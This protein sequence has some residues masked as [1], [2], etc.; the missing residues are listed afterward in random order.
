MMVLMWRDE[1]LR[2]QGRDGTWSGFLT[3]VPTGPYT[4]SLN[5][6]KQYL[7]KNSSS[8]SDIKTSQE[9]ETAD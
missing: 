5:V 2:L 3:Q 1:V 8:L 9:T 4:R 7:D 6:C